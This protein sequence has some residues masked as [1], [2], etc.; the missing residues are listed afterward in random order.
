M[1][2]VEYATQEWVDCYNHRRLL[3]SIDDMPPAEAEARY[4]E[5][6]EPADLAA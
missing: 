1:D 4:S 3:A 6:L 2:V 5:Q